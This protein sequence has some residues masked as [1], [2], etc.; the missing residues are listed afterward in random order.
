MLKSASAV[1]Y[2]SQIGD[3]RFETM[4]VAV[5]QD[6][7]MP[8]A[9]TTTPLYPWRSLQIGQSFFSTARSLSTTRWHRDTGYTYETRHVQENGRS[10]IRCWR[11]A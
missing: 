8:K 11:T 10:G 1:C 9:D 6:I 5:D 3:R 7:P 4:T 2:H